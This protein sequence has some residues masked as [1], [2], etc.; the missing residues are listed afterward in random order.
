[1][2]KSQRWNIQNSLFAWDSDFN[3]FFLKAD[4]HDQ[5]GKKR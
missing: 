1:M 4:P 5:L 3:P 2:T